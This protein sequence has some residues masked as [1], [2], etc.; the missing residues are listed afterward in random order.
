[1]MLLATSH[2]HGSI[3][4]SLLLFALL[5]LVGVIRFTFRKKIKNSKYKFVSKAPFTF[6]GVKSRR[7]R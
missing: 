4:V 7:K 3:I 2:H 5:I 6:S 1:M